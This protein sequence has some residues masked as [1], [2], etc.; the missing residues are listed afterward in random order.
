MRTAELMSPQVRTF[1]DP[2]SGLR[3]VTFS[4]ITCNNQVQLNE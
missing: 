2:R 3:Y 4:I 1:G